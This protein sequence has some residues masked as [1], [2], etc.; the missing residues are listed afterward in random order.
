MQKEDTMIVDYIGC[1]HKH[2][3]EFHINRPQGLETH[4][5]L[6]I[7]TPGLFSVDGEL[8]PVRKNSF[9]IYKAGVPHQYRANKEPYIDDFI[10]FQFEEGDEE[11]FLSHNIIFNRPVYVGELTE[12]SEILRNMCFEF[13]TPSE[14]RDEGMN[15]YF[16]LLILK[17]G[18]AV[19]G[20]ALTSTELGSDHFQSLR[21]IREKIFSTHAFHM[22]IDEMAHAANVSR[23]YF[24]HTYKM[25]FGQSVRDD[26]LQSR[27]SHAK[28]LLSTTKVPVSAI[29]EQC[30]YNNDVH[31]MRQ[32]KN[33][34][35]LTPTEYR[36]HF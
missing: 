26:I 9:V 12:C 6:L 7:K 18:R 31:F 17:L 34:T 8:V 36:K 15:L 11:F 27:M 25:L 21:A 19:R 20:A 4:L 16:R 22:S 1:H 5:L 14:D 32:F 29:A 35:G 3:E 2:T 13:C 10:H 24:Q 30:G 23:S 28:L 33:Y